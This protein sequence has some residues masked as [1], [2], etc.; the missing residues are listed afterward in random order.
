MEQTK[1]IMV[2][3]K[4]KAYG[5]YGRYPQ[6]N[7]P[8]GH[9]SNRYDKLGEVIYEGTGMMKAFPNLAQLLAQ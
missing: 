7:R 4:D 9:Y 1:K 2:V 6:I 5:K 8:V 3:Y